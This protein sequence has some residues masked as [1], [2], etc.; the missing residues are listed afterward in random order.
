MGATCLQSESAGL[1]MMSL[2]P[3]SRCSGVTISCIMVGVLSL[4]E[5]LKI[6]IEE[7][8]RA[9]LEENLNIWTPRHLELCFLLKLYI[10]HLQSYA[11]AKELSRSPVAVDAHD[12]RRDVLQMIYSLC[13]FH[14]STQ[15]TLIGE[16][17]A[18][19]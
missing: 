18:E 6:S 10:T 14:M 15:N 1:I 13:E 9:R 4:S 16:K 2:G 19:R 12:R 11:C 7:A 8:T 3:K 17:S 5:Q